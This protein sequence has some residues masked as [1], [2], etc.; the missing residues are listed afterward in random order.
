MAHEIF[1]SYAHADNEPLTEGLRG[2]IDMLHER[3][4]N[5]L[6]VELGREAKIWR[7]KKMPP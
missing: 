6:R 5:Q 2:W 4:N 7:D 3:L 1:I